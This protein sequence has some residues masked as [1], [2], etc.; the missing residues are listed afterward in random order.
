MYMYTHM[1]IHVRDFVASRLPSLSRVSSGAKK[2]ASSL[3]VEQ[4][5]ITNRVNHIYIYIYIYT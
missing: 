3:G 5:T 2:T 4:S 1:H